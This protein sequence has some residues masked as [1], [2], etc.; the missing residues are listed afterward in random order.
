MPLI[1]LKTY[2]FN[3]NG[4]LDLGRLFDFRFDEIAISQNSK[5]LVT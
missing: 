5:I 1:F 4:L 3:K 2:F